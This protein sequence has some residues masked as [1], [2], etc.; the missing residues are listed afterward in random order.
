[1]GIDDQQVAR[2]LLERDQVLVDAGSRFGDET[3][4]YL[5]IDLG[6]PDD[7]LLTGIDRIVARV[8]GMRGGE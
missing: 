6:A 2:S 4:G 1:L 8:T 5:R 3:A 7:V